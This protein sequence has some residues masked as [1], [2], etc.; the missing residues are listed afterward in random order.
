ML[1]SAPHSPSLPVADT[2][3]TVSKGPLP[4]GMERVCAP[5]CRVWRRLNLCS[6]AWFISGGGFTSHP[7]GIKH[8][9]QALLQRPILYLPEPMTHCGCDPSLAW[10]FTSACEAT[11]VCSKV[12]LI[13]G[14][15]C[16]QETHVMGKSE[17]PR[18]PALLCS[19]VPQGL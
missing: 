13:E 7:E 12:Q 2:C 19:C 5:H 14:R 15:Y 8:S 3:S 16:L 18:I 9:I 11:P 6:L 1:P 17:A 10:A 4:G